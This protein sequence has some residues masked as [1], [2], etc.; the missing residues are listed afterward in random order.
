MGVKLRRARGKWY[1]YIDW[2]GKRKCKC[3]G[4]NKQLAEEIR[5]QV[6][7]KLALGDLNILG[8]SEQGTTFQEYAE[9]W[10]S[11]YAELNCKP[12]T[13]RGYKNILKQYV[14]PKLGRLKL[15]IS[16]FLRGID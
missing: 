3:V 2:N 5:R 7:A 15:L 10:L 8:A 12:S 4:T 11:E 14:Y 6:E 16:P 13:A 1:L 9:R